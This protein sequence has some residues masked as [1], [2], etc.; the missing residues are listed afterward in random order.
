M[1]FA[2]GIG[3][4][5]KPWTDFHPKALVEIGGRPMLWHVITRLKDAG[6]NTI[7][8]NVHHFADQIERYLADNRFDGVEIVVSDER[9]L[10]LDTGGG[11]RKAAEWL[12]GDGPVILHNAD[13]F[14]DIDLKAMISRHI[15][16]GADAT[17]LMSCRESS[18]ALVFDGSMRLAGWHNLKTGAVLPESLRIDSPMQELAFGGVHIVGERVLDALG[19][20]QAGTPFSITPF[21]VEASGVL[22]IRG[23]LPVREGY[24][25]DVGRPAT[26]E[27]ARKIM[28]K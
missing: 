24:W 25:Y 4:R 16:S 13:I 18:R 11:L 27:S 26:L 7:V 9:E 5:L 15:S 17:L 28:E 20:Y 1:I 12:R 10:L 21:Y 3:S 22:D 2:A 19:E 14:T 8:V 6:A 23:Y